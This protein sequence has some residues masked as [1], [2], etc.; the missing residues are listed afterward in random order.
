[1]FYDSV[2]LYSQVVTLEGWAE[3]MFF[4][5]DTHSFWNFVFFILVTIVSSHLSLF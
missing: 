3:I 4:V 2:S 1:M 5:M